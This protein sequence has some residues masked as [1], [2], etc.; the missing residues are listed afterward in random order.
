MDFA[1]EL[2]SLND[3]GYLFDTHMQK[4][5]DLAAAFNNRCHAL[6][7][8]GR[9]EEALDDCNVSL[10]YGQLPDTIHKQQEL[11]RMLARP[12]TAESPR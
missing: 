4:D 9:L 10:K 3:H 7:E 12:A 6:M 11:Q 2:K 8:L 1:G 5:D